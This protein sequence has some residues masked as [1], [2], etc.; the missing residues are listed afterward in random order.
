M[1]YRATPNDSGKS[2]S[3]VFL[4]RRIRT[5]LDLIKPNPKSRNDSLFEHDVRSFTKG[6][7]VLVKNEYS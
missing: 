2:P 5:R 7:E 4:G 6:D 1:S 3:E